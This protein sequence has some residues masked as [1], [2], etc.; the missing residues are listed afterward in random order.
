MLHKRIYLD[1]TDE[2]VYIDTY[3]TDTNFKKKDAMLVIPGGGYAAVCTVR[4]GEPI[5]LAYVA[6]G[7]NAF[8]LNYRVG[9]G[10][11]FPSQLVDASRAIMYI[12]AH[13]EEFSINP[14][15]V[16]AVGFSAGGHLAGTLATMYDDPAVREALGISGDENKPTGCVLSY[17]VVTANTDNTHKSSFE[18]LLGKKFDDIT[19]DEKVRFSLET[20]V[21]D[22]SAPLFVWHTAEDALVP[23]EGSLR[24]INEYVK[25]KIPVQAA[26]YPYGPHGLALANDMT[27]DGRACIQ[28]IAQRWVADSVEWMNTIKRG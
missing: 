9:N 1:P 8:V 21:T 4:E 28:P 7:Y 20:R 13:A 2:R 19:V 5:A 23:A 25:R 6:K 26:I 10:D 14:E 22:N 3:V 18:M 12:R 27:T 11:H 16:F 17:P 24:L 15:R